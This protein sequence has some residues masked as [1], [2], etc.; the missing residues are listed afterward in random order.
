MTW[1]LGLLVQ[2]APY[3]RD[4]LL[5]SLSTNY[6]GIRRAELPC[7]C[8]LGATAFFSWQF[9][10]RGQGTSDPS[11]RS[12]HSARS[13][14]A[15]CCAALGV[16]KD[17]RDFLAR[18]VTTKSDRY[19]REARLVIQR[20]QL[21]VA[22]TLRSRPEAA[23]VIGELETLAEIEEILEARYVPTEVVS[24][25]LLRLARVSFQRAE[26]TRHCQTQSV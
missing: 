23:A 19:V 2:I 25:Q 1:A 13:C 7:E 26:Q 24:R 9:D 18:W 5:P 6:G 4:Y 14:M 16:P 20:L 22:L 17:E 3:R 21:V 8:S 10:T 11:P 12:S 15:T